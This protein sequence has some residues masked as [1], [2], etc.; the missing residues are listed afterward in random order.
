MILL[1][2]RILLISLALAALAACGDDDENAPQMSM[3]AP[4]MEPKAFA[5]SDGDYEIAMEPDMGA[6]EPRIELVVEEPTLNDRSYKSE[7]ETAKVNSISQ[8]GSTSGN[9]M[10]V[11]RVIVRSAEIDIEV[12]DIPNALNSIGTI[13]TSSGGWVVAS[14]QTRTFAG[15]ISIRIP[16]EKLDSALEQIRNL[17][18]KVRTSTITS[19]DLTEEFTDVS[20][21][22]QTLSDTKAVLT[23]L[24]DQ[25]KNVEEA[26]SI[27]KEI[28]RVQSDLEALEARIKFISESEAYSLI[29]VLMQAAPVLMSVDA[30]PDI[31]VGVMNTGIPYGSPD[32]ENRSIFRARFSPPEGIDDFIITWN[33]G[34]GSP[35]ESTDRVA[36]AT[37][38]GELIS[39]SIVHYFS[40]DDDSPLIVTVK[41][42]GSGDAGLAEGEDTQ[43]VTVSRIPPIVVFAGTDQTVEASQTVELSGSFTLPESITDV[44]YIWDFG[45]GSPPEE[46]ELVNAFSAGNVTTE[47]IFPHFRWNPYEVRLR[48][49]GKSEIGEITGEATTY[50]YVQETVGVSSPDLDIPS[51]IRS[52]GRALQAVGVISVN[53]LLWLAILSPV[54]IVGVVLFLFFRKRL[55][56]RIFL[57]SKPRKFWQRKQ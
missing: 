35:E 51:T 55:P 37:E 40:R 11:D 26:L 50:I 1:C 54:W 30:G 46:N 49:S 19:Q 41:V 29:H 20:A 4:A 23:G 48:V 53:I 27:Q 36:P 18:T 47:H 9:P 12:Q 14:D 43:L 39:A 44:R 15:S 32:M 33:F 17:S 45:D 25:A 3:T 13:A 2:V 22:A 57:F 31:A 5:R 7:A 16:A 21:R 8:S 24:F 38:D 6:P 56:A 52:A 10:N 34:D 42:R 28:T